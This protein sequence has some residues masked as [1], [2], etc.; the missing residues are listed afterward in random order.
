[1]NFRNLIS[2]FLVLMILILP[3][4][5]ALVPDQS[6]SIFSVGS[7]GNAMEATLNISFLEVT[8]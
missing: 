5:S 7:S 4:V 8:G 6:M 2:I 3:S 1:M